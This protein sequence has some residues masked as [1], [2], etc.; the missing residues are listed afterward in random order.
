MAK[1]NQKHKIGA[2]LQGDDPYSEIRGRTVLIVEDD[3]DQVEILTEQLGIFGMEVAGVARSAS[4][5]LRLAE[6]HEPSLVIMDIV[7]DGEDRDGIEIAEE[8]YRKNK[9]L[10][11]ILRSGHCNGTFVARA[12]EAGILT[13]LVKPT[14]M[15]TLFPAIVLTLNGYKM[16][17]IKQA[18]I[19]ELK[20][21]LENRIIID[22]AKG[23]LMKQKHI[24]EQKAYIAIRKASQ[25]ENK[26][27]VEV[28]RCILTAQ[29]VHE[30][31]NQ[32][33]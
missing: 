11:I 15:E 2:R 33:H 20:E 8:L 1:S 21:L 31:I 3:E 23:F 6:K 10:A 19:D 18:Q 16:I 32:D 29:T 26:P 28:A 22:R 25:N 12:R 13:Y 27:I 9:T 4:E 30:I 5:A 24:D 7:L 17:I 14:S